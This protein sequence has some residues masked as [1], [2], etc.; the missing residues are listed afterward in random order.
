MISRIC[1]LMLG[2]YRA[3]R[4]R[5]IMTKRAPLTCN[6]PGGEHCGFANL[7]DDHEQSGS[8]Y[9]S[10]SSTTIS[11]VVAPTASANTRSKLLAALTSSWRAATAI[12]NVFAASFA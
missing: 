6:A 12:P 4:V 11:L 7:P 1:S 2:S 5:T 9:P 8:V 10:V 3:C